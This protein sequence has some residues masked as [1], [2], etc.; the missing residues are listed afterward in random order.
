MDVGAKNPSTVVVRTN[1]R[2]LLVLIS[3]D[4]PVVLQTLVVA[5]TGR[6]LLRVPTERGVSDVMLQSMDVVLT[7]SHQRPDQTQAA[8][9]VL[10]Q[11]MAAAL[12]VCLRRLEKILKAVRRDQGRRVTCLRMVDTEKTSQF[13]GILTSRRGA[14]QDFGMEVKGGTRMP[15]QHLKSVRRYVSH[16]LVQQCATC[17]GRRESALVRPL[18]GITTRSSNNATPSHTVAAWAMPIG[19]KAERI[20]KE[21]V[22]RQTTSRFVNSH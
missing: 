11:H 16:H 14:A 20:A 10:D 21:L 17:P 22:S 5:R 15:F 7:I 13:F 19:S 6:Q 1:T 3:W 4:V 9:V 2:L 18:C 8:V 12:M